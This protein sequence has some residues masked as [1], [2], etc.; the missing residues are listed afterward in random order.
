MVRYNDN[1]IGK[2]V[3]YIREVTNGLKYRYLINKWFIFAID[4][5][6]NFI[7]TLRYL[8]HKYHKKRYSINIESLKEIRKDLRYY[9]HNILDYKGHA[10]SI[11]RIPD[12]YIYVANDIDCFYNEGSSNDLLEICELVNNIYTCDCNVTEFIINKTFK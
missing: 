11:K 1:I 6:P 7:S 10:Y 4:T 3:Y 2:T 5:Q 12:N 9:T 8:I